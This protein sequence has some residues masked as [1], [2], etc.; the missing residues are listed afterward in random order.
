MRAAPLR[1]LV[2]AVLGLGAL[3]GVLAT[4]SQAGTGPTDVQATITM[5][6]GVVLAAETVTATGPGPHP[7]VV[8]PGSWSSNQ[9]QYHSIALLFGNAG[10]DVVGYS[11]RGMATSQGLA[12]YADPASIADLSSVIDWAVQHL[13][14]DPNQV[15]AMGISYGAGI[16]LLAAEQDPRIK[17]VVALSTWTDLGE[18]FLPSGSIA[19]G[20][21]NALAVA[22]TGPTP[23]VR[24]GPLLTTL[25]GEYTSNPTAARKLIT[26]MSPS[27]SPIT[28]VAALSNTAVMLA[29]GFQDSLLPPR[30]LVTMFGKL[31]GPRRLEL[32]TGDHGQPE[33]AA[34]Y[35][36]SAAGPI[37]DALAWM[38]RFVRGVPNGV[39]KAKPVVLQDTVT[40][41]VT[42]YPRWPGKTAQTQ[43][44]TAPATLDSDP[45]AV[46]I[47][48]TDG[49]VDWTRAIQWGLNTPAETSYEQTDLLD[50]Y[51]VQTVAANT[52]S[53]YFSFIW[54]G[55]ELAAAQALAGSPTATVTVSSSTPTVSLTGY[56]FDVD[57][58]GTASLMSAAPMTVNGLK[59]GASKSV[60]LLFNPIAWTLA[61]G[62]HVTLVIDSS[63]HRWAA[64]NTGNPTLTITSTTDQPSRLVLPT[65]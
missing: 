23:K 20:L 54:N 31:P 25:F 53:K 3:S 59:L 62:H 60:T 38:D 57:A 58:T 46:S 35:G 11:D 48:A 6:D 13:A 19:N 45:Q 29:N 65:V 56:L 34:L 37:A 1:L 40:G 64:S 43:S 18:T 41:V 36:G 27:R 26:S 33:A 5:P 50:P 12:D 52:F 30:E 7:L 28:N 55:S 47:G 32:R 42:S 14:A 15:G 39:D 63:D 8:M 4:P 10:Y 22:T 24:T 9:L 51:R 21:L 16:S 17:S 49:S 44:L 61:A 2:S